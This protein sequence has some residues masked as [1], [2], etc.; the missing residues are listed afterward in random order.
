MARGRHLHDNYISMGFV[1]EGSRLGQGWGWGGGG[2]GQ[3]TR[4]QCP[5]EGIWE[6]SAVPSACGACG[7][8]SVGQ[9]ERPSERPT[10]EQAAALFVPSSCTCRWQNLCGRWGGLATAPREDRCAR[11]G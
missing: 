6:T 1:E 11:Y 8:C 5:A 9:R 2:R 4:A 10:E 7:H 3:S